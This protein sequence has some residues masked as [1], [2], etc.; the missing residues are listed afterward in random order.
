MNKE[1]NETEE[2]GTDR[3]TSGRNGLAPRVT[4]VHKDS[5]ISTKQKPDPGGKGG[6]QKDWISRKE[7]GL[8]FC[9]QSADRGGKGKNSYQDGEE[10]HTP[11]T[12]CNRFYAGACHVWRYFFPDEALLCS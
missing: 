10:Y 5:W 8:E 3:K 7:T 12:N 1:N 6:V 9:C 11:Q 4:F 2:I